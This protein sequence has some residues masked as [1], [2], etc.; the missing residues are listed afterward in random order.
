MKKEKS[1]IMNEYKLRINLL[2]EVTI[3][4]GNSVGT[5]IDSDIVVDSFGIP[6][7]PAK[8]IKGCLRDSLNELIYLNEIEKLGINEELLNEGFGNKNGDSKGEIHFSNLYIHNYENIKEW[9]SYLNLNKNTIF[10]KESIISYYTIIQRQTAIENDTAKEHS[11][12]TFRLLKKDLIFEGTIYLPNTNQR[13]LKLISIATLNL[14]NI[15]TRRNRGY[16]SIECSILDHS[17]A[18]IA[19]SL[20]KQMAGKN[21]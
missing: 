6:Y 10:N 16:G 9:C 5:F 13:L 19:Y 14:R 2:S 17:G 8:R 4:S 7:I 12:R 3:G 21:E 1:I 20:V 18:N 15:G 11:L